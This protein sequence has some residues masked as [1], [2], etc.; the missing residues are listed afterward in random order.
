MIL[1]KV[2]SATGDGG[3]SGG[4]QQQSQQQGQ[5]QQ[6]TTT[7]QTQQQTTWTPPTR[8]EWERREKDLKDARAEAAE[9]RTKLKEFEEKQAQT[10]GNYK[11]LYEQS[12][13]RI[14]ELEPFEQSIKAECTALRTELG[15]K[16]K[17]VEKLP[18]AQ[19]LPILRELKAAAAGPGAAGG[20]TAG[21]PRSAAAD[22]LPDFTGMSQEQIQNEIR[23]LP[24]DQRQKLIDQYFPKAGPRNSF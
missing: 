20:T 11:D 23:K 5:T 2:L 10:S 14:A 17:L 3:G 7:Q 4:G 13:R 22:K 18:D 6:T 21:A 12:T 9:R 1:R 15:D 16:A 19:A 8:E 24:A